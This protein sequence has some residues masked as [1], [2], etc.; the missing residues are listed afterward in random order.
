MKLLLTVLAAT[1]L[2]AGCSTPSGPITPETDEQGRYVIHM[3]A[4]NRFSPMKAT[5]PVG[6]T[7][8]FVVDGGVHDV[9]AHDNSWSSD[10]APPAGLGGK[11]QAGEEFEHTFS[12]A[13]SVPY[14]C[15]LHASSG[16]TATLL[17]E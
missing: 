4:S 15:N 10:K 9:T 13:G 12:E 11:M 2:L 3:T 8:V 14:H 16:M 17:V 5:V 1:L 6:S 7:V